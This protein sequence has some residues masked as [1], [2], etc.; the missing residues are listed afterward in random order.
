M[1]LDEKTPSQG[2]AHFERDDSDV[3][4]KDLQTFNDARA[5]NENEHELT[6]RQGLKAYPW[7]VMW[8]LI[9]S[10]SIVMEG[11]DTN[12]IGNVS[13]ASTLAI[14][15]HS[16]TRVLIDLSTALRIPGIQGT[17]RCRAR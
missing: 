7:A 13:P 17:I 14:Y 1:S 8:A 9:I 2:V 15:R 11:Y 5:A 6:I 16:L 4:A 10:M 3:K 12:L